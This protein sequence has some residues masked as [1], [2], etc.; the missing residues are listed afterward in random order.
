MDGLAI[1]ATANSGV[2]SKTCSEIASGGACSLIGN[3]GGICCA[4]CPDDS[5]CG[6][7]N[8]CVDDPEGVL[9]HFNTACPASPASCDDLAHLSLMPSGG[10]G[11]HFQ[12]GETVADLC[13]ALCGTCRGHRRTE[14]LVVPSLLETL[15]T[16]AQS[17]THENVGEQNATSAPASQLRKL[18][19]NYGEFVDIDQ[20]E[21][22]TCTFTD[23]NDRVDEMTALCCNENTGSCADGTPDICGFACGRAFI[24]FMEQCLPILSIWVLT[25]PPLC[26]T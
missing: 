11:S 1:L 21:H 19:Q 17:A 9:A 14:D 18:Q 24:P 25:L 13:P 16:Q 2:P 23:F 15:A 26:Y 7:C 22:P 8:L 20:F 4:S 12:S 5:S 3:L 10:D 6:N